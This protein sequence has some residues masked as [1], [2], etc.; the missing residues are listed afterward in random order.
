MSALVGENGAG[1]T[2]LPRILSDARKPAD[3][4]GSCGAALA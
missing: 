1:K 4:G 3:G 2:T